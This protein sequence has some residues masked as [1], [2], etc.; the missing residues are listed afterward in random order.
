MHTP[1]PW[2]R[3]LGADGVYEVGAGD[4]VLARVQRREVS[5]GFKAG[6]SDEANARLIAAAP[7][8]L[9]ALEDL[10]APYNMSEDYQAKIDRAR[11]AIK[12]AKGE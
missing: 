3:A 8:L 12:K 4:E 2:W 10:I 6:G 1:G 9:A 5:F 11:A 7:E